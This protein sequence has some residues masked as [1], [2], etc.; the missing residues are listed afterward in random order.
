MTGEWIAAL[1]LAA[2]PPAGRGR[3]RH[4]DYLVLEVTALPAPWKNLAL[5]VA[6]FSNSRGLVRPGQFDGAIVP[7][8]AEGDLRL[9]IE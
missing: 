2:S 9:R 5:F 7:L 1:A 6:P 3:N 4:Q 8:K